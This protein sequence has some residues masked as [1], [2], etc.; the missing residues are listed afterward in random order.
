MENVGSRRRLRMSYKD[1]VAGDL[2]E[3]VGQEKRPLIC[4]H[5][6]NKT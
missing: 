3:K 5:G 1:E 2:K 6:R 4:I